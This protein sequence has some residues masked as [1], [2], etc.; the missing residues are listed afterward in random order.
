[1]SS[2]SENPGFPS[3]LICLVAY[4]TLNS[5]LN[6]LN[7]WLLGV[8]KFQFPVLLS[9]LH[10]A[11]CFLAL[12]PFMLLR[13]FRDLHTT[14]IRKQWLGL[15]VIGICFALNLGLNN[16]SLVTIS[17]SLNQVIRSSLPVI[18]AVFAAIIEQKT[19]T[20]SEFLSLLLLVVGVMIA[21]YQG[22]KQ[23]DSLVGVL[24]CVGST[25]S[26]AI[27]LSTSGKLLSEKL[28]VL[29]LTFYTAP[30]TIVSLFP[31]YLI[32][33]HKRLQAYGI[34]EGFK[35][36]PV[37]VLGCVVALS[38]NLVHHLMI[39]WTSSVTITVIGEVKMV[40]LLVLSALLLGE[41]RVWTLKMT[42]GILLALCGFV[43]Y[44]H[45]KLSASDK[46]QEHRDEEKTGLLEPIMSKPGASD[47]LKTRQQA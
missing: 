15:L 17:L 42:T 12:L 35:F 6:M 18:V 20:R 27:M 19:P 28:D 40:I 8:F 30:V 37:L 16:T 1:M 21:A 36:V 7:R 31:C 2:R 25:V 10:L 9:V 24:T 47:N 32:L 26:N 11:F 41:A 14:T 13:R 4:L 38:Y 29:R 22:A 34:Q 45:L 5:V 39:Q 46:S 44:S 43:L 33:E 23:E 3:R